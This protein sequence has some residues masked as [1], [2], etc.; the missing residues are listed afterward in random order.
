VTRDPEAFRQWQADYRRHLAT[1]PDDYPE[2]WLSTENKIRLRAED[3]ERKR[4]ADQEWKAWCD[5]A[6][7]GMRGRGQ[8][9]KD[10]DGLVDAAVW[11]THLF[12]GATR[13]QELN[14]MADELLACPVP[15]VRALVG[16]A[17]QKRLRN[18]LAAS[19][20]G[21]LTPDWA[22]LSSAD[23]WA[24][25]EGLPALPLEIFAE[26]VPAGVHFV[27][28]SRVRHCERDGLLLARAIRD[29]GMADTA[30]PEAQRPL[31]RLLDRLAKLPDD[32]LSMLGRNDDYDVE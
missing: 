26:I 24:E 18:L 2:P 20:E 25:Q 12:R 31:Q 3:R 29:S 1:K 17:K 6:V 28:A 16:K 22:A 13:A 15:A 5:A 8:P 10:V 19:A 32:E 14:D 11:L 27:R 7:R 4:A 9:A 30:P 23:E 21:I